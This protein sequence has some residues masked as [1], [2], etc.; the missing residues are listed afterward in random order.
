MSALRAEYLRYESM[1]QK[2]KGAW[3]M[4]PL[5]RAYHTSMRSR[6]LYTYIHIKQQQQQNKTK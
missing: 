4:A 1:L 3:E 5:V 6:L 2:E